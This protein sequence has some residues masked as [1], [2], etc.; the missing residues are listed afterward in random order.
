MIFKVQ[1]FVLLVGLFNIFH[2]NNEFQHTSELFR[3]SYAEP[4]KY[5]QSMGAQL[6]LPTKCM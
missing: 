1:L 2:L 3:F 6:F 4:E 5:A